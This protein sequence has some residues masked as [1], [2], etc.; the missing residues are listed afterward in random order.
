MK[1]RLVFVHGRSQEH[2]NAREL[3]NEWIEA[4]AQGLAK[5]GLSMPI[6]DAEIAFPYYGQTLFDLVSGKQG[7]EI[8]E[9]IARS[10]REDEHQHRFMSNVLNEVCSH[11]GA[12]DDTSVL[13][14]DA[15]VMERG[16]LNDK[17]VR[18]IIQT[19]EQRVPG[20]GGAAVALATTD[21]YQ[22]LKNPGIRDQI[23]EGVRASL[24][25]ND[26]CTVVGHSLGSVVGYNILRR[27]GNVLGLRVPLFVTLGS[28]LA[29]GAIAKAL[30]PVRAPACVDR[31]YN[32][33]DPR[34]IVALYPLDAQRFLV[35]PPIVNKTDVD[36]FTPNRHGIAGYLS[37][38][39]VARC[40][41]EAVTAN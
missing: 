13:S 7:D 16:L 40:I 23:E 33:M 26:R 2:K 32:A 25:G 8:A 19:I 15:D 3:K 9:V 27:D 21:V 22:Y 31:W 20:G 28:P 5:S 14:R 38:R 18:N 37:D 36:N 41:Y 30:R 29:V 35:E 34:D 12:T 17:F 1:I 4:W 6:E 39:E 10:A 24:A 11:I